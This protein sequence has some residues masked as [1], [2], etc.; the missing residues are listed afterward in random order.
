MMTLFSFSHQKTKL[1][2]YARDGKVGYSMTGVRESD[3]TIRDLTDS[4]AILTQFSLFGTLSSFPVSRAD[5][6]DI[7][8][9]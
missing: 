1:Q 2:T 4:Q 5:S 3:L 8:Y 7:Q 9:F 6:S